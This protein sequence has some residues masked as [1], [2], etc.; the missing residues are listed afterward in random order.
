[1][2]TKQI[3]AEFQK[4]L[5]TTQSPGISDFQVYLIQGTSAKEVRSI[6]DQ[7]EDNE[8][9]KFVIGKT[10]ENFI[11]Q[12]MLSGDIRP[13][14]A[15]QVLKNEHGW[16]RGNFQQQETGTHQVILSLATPPPVKVKLKKKTYK[17]KAVTINDVEYKSVK[18]A[19][20]SG[21]FDVGAEL[22]YKR[23]SSSSFPKWFFTNEVEWE[24][25]AQSPDK[26]QSQA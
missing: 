23:A 24:E 13:D 7:I 18:E 16:E 3:Y 9:L 12:G 14:A 21:L 15:K 1:M 19:Q 26:T 20:A 8:D 25:E 10:C 5:T 22:I 11:I 4:Y 6:I 2:T 17:N